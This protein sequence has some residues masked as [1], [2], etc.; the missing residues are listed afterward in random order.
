MKTKKRKSI[1]GK[2]RKE[3]I[4]EWREDKSFT[5][6]SKIVYVCS[7]CG[8]WQSVKRRNAEQICYMNFCPF[9]GAKM[10][11]PSIKE[12]KKNGNA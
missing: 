5:S 4:G 7:E 6:E 8:H 10:K 9:C 1:S 3:R 2:Y 11:K 12:V